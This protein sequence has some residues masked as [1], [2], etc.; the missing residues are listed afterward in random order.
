MST[1][2]DTKV[3]TLKEVPDS[4]VVRQT[5]I[6]EIT[7]GF[8]RNKD[9]TVFFSRGMPNEG[10]GRLPTFWPVLADGRLSR[11][12]SAVPNIEGG[13]DTKLDVLNPEE[14]EGIEPLMWENGDPVK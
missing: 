1:D 5:T 2:K 10:I 7:R 11:C 4:A 3:R 13:W 6:R 9:G 12:G 14:I 8:F